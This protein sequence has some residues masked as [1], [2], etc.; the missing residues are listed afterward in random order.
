MG[1]QTCLVFT[2]KQNFVSR[3]SCSPFVSL[4]LIELML[5]QLLES[6]SWHFICKIRTYQL[7]LLFEVIWELLSHLLTVIDSP[8]VCSNKESGLVIVKVEIASIPCIKELHPAHSAESSKLIRCPFASK[9]KWTT[10]ERSVWRSWEKLG[11]IGK[12]I[13]QASLR[14]CLQ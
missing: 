9:D 6:F 3:N 2:S 12:C 11:S 14:L 7:H 10:W 4:S 5:D 1:L 13:C 8:V